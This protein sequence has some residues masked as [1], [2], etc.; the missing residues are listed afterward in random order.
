MIVLLADMGM[1]VSLMRL[2]VSVHMLMHQL[3]VQMGVLMHQIGGEEK[4]VVG[5]NAL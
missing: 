2:P 4:L 3:A 5:E 1:P